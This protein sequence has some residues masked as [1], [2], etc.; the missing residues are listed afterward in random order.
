PRA[1]A[2]PGPVRTARHGCTRRGDTRPEPRPR[3][4]GAPGADGPGGE[5]PQPGGVRPGSWQL[6]DERGPHLT[7]DDRF[8][9]D[10]CRP[11]DLTCNLLD[12][13]LAVVRH[14]PE[15]GWGS[16]C[17]CGRHDRYRIVAAATAADLAQ[18]RTDLWDSGWRTRDDD[19][20]VPY[21]GRPLLPRQAVHWKVGIADRDEVCWSRPARFVTAPDRPSGQWVWASEVTPNQH[22]LLRGA[23]TLP[24]GRVEHALLSITA[25]DSFVL[26]ADGQ[27][28][29]RGPCP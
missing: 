3:Q 14:N 20:L 22:L 21:D 24:P 5:L 17:R 15:L 19:A 26:W 2:V 9:T 27:R 18:G 23:V 6:P 16:S 29:G 1:L 13:P 25:D 8:P 28:L 11:A 12:T 4:Q 10:R 7:M